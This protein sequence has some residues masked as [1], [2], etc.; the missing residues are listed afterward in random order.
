MREILSR[1]DEV[2]H[3]SAHQTSPE[4]QLGVA[5]PQSELMRKLIEPCMEIL[6]LRH[7][8]TPNACEDGSLP[9]P[10]STSWRLGPSCA[11]P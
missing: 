9:E 8:T 5:R 6:S 11:F 10:G 1:A 3:V 7:G 2:P 4:Q